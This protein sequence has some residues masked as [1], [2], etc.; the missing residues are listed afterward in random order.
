MLDPE[1]VSGQTPN[2]HEE[3]PQPTAPGLNPTVQSGAHMP[4]GTRREDVVASL[5]RG[6]TP[7]EASASRSGFLRTSAKIVGALAVSAYVV[8]AFDKNQKPADIFFNNWFVLLGAAIV[9]FGLP[10]QY[11]RIR[12]RN[13]VTAETAELLA[14]SD[15]P[16]SRCG[17]LPLRGTPVCASCHN[18]LR[19]FGVIVPAA[20]ILLIA[21]IVLLYR[22][23]AFS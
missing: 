9:P 22:H 17:E 19:P 3:F 18:L 8:I 2:R 14:P 13:P 15:P 20:I 1:R 21:L 10:I 12:P 5:I 11:F 4:W 16:C 23:G 7:E 6:I